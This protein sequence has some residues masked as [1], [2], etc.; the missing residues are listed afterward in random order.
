VAFRRKEWGHTSVV[1]ALAYTPDSKILVA[2][3]IDGS[4][5]LWDAEAT[6]LLR[7][8]KT[9]SL[10]VYAIAIAP[11]GK[12]L[13]TAG[14]W[15]EVQIWDIDS[16]REF[17]VLKGHDGPVAA[18]TFS[19]NGKL[20][21]TGGYD[22]SIRLWDT[23]TWGGRGHSTLSIKWNVPFCLPELRQRLPADDR[24]APR[25]RESDEE[26]HVV[27]ARAGG[28]AIV[29]DEWG[30]RSR[31]RCA[32]ERNIVWIVGHRASP[33]LEKTRPRSQKSAC[34]ERRWSLTLQRKNIAAIENP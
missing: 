7:S 21:A 22:K 1:T 26:R 11:D 20:L 3:S 24:V 31:S 14:S 12:K 10:E 9:L 29:T 6:K 15:G 23:T 2:A 17:Y 32:P 16:G 5:R 28:V 33:D 13:A 25:R 8:L 18:V 19:P 34:P 30:R 4:V 27:S